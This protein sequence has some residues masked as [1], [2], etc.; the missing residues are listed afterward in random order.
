MKYKLIV[1]INNWKKNKKDYD[2]V[3]NQ[4][5]AD[6]YPDLKIKF[7]VADRFNKHIYVMEKG[8]S[9]C[10][11]D[12]EF[13]G[14]KNS[15]IHELNTLR[16]SLSNKNVIVKFPWKFSI[17]SAP[18]PPNMHVLKIKIQRSDVK[19]FDINFPSRTVEELLTRSMQGSKVMVKYGDFFSV[20]NENVGV[21][22]KGYSSLLVDFLS[23]LYGNLLHNKLSVRFPLEY[24]LIVELRKYSDQI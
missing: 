2:K 11:E 6:S 13:F 4:I 21:Y 15:F 24:P 8:S 9:G 1:N 17:T 22:I 19:E 18:R 23:S 7:H 14:N 5:F 16:D 20:E 3:I 12:W 10:E